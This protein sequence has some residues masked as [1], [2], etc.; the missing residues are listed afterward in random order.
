MAQ[1]YGMTGFARVSG[2]AEWGTW[3]WE[4][5][6]VNG[7]GLDVRVSYPQGLDTFERAA[8]TEAAKRMKRGSLQTARNGS[9]VVTLYHWLVG[10][11]CFHARD[12]QTGTSPSEQF[13]FASL[14]PEP[15]F[16]SIRW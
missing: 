4:A 13:G 15:A 7:R 5:K 14:L 10:D 12:T 9:L 2:E 8:K 6:S 16:E 3:A 1:L 11:T